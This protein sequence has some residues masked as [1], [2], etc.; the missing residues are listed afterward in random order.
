MK[1]KIERFSKGDFEYEQPFLF[2]SDEEIKMTVE[3]GKLAKGSF[4]IKNSTGRE[5]KGM[6]YS[7]NRLM[8]IDIPAFAGA[9]ATIEFQFNA[10]FLKEGELI[11][12]EF[13]IVSDCGETILPFSI[14]TESYYYMT[15][16]GK[17]KDLFQF[18]NLARMDWSEAKKV[19]RSEEFER[20]FLY[21]EE[22]YRFVY[23]NLIKSVS[24]SQA[25]E[26]FL[27]AIHKKAAIRLE[28]DRTSVEYHMDQNIQS[29]K[30]LL[31]KNNWGY[32]EIRVSTDAA[33]IQLE[34][35]FLWA[36]RFVGNT[37]HIAYHINP[38]NL[39]CGNN[40]GHI[41]IKTS[42]QTITV[43][44]ICKYRRDTDSISESRILR[45]F[46][47]GLV[48][49]YLALRLNRIDL[50]DYLNEAEILIKQLPGPEINR[51]KELMKIHLSIIAGRTKIAKELL[52]DIASEEKHLRQKSILIYCTYLYLDALYRKDDDTIKRAADI[53][54]DYYEKG[55]SDWRLLWF[56]FYLDKRYDN[57]KSVKLSDI[58]EQYDAGCRSPILYYEAVCIYNEEPFLLRELSDFEV[59]IL[60]F[61][62]KNWILSKETAAQ[63][64]YLSTKKKNFEQ[65]VYNGLCKLYDE[66]GTTEILSAICS[67]LIKGMKK[68]EKYFEWYRLGVDAQ[69]RIT[70][71]YEY[72]MYSISDTTG[73]PL[74]Q[75][76]LL[77]FI[78]N[79]SLNDKKKA[80]LY[81]NIVK[82]K[83]RNE[84]IYR[85]Y[86]KRMEV[87]HHKDVGEPPD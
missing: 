54:R 13:C 64:T 8:L 58:K 57:N 82:H 86:Y 36:D 66:Y 75:P 23:R 6:V 38:K 26:E 11:E 51:Y 69:L 34:Q 44:V 21:R 76:I 24:T 41:F 84:S 60:N 25:L 68:D 77:Y 81:S 70:E 3:A 9:D 12:G 4:S 71:L 61:G 63:Y 14:Q 56:L 50:T 40:F 7:S 48:D 20:I 16:L 15:S 1:E 83:D 22:R 65:V 18:T 46:E 31:T 47:C 30:L 78:Y 32:A 2:L 17:I 59:Q 43:E 35:K 49:N 39:K 5:M 37:H 42:G 62:I 45:K 28:I 79:S 19:F 33:F 74:P 29:D 85:S 27:I 87:S 80:F 52:E 73:E 55:N 53:I 72:Y 10:T 67:M